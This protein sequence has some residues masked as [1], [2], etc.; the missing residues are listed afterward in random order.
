MGNNYCGK[1][2]VCFECNIH[3]G[4]TSLETK[5]EKRI[6]GVELVFDGYYAKLRVCTENCWTK[7]KPKGRRAKCARYTRVVGILAVTSLGLNLRSGGKRLHWRL[8]RRPSDT[9][10]YYSYAS[11]LLLLILQQKQKSSKVHHFWFSNLWYVFMLYIFFF[12]P[13][14]QCGLV[15]LSFLCFYKYYLYTLI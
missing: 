15:F 11:S 7:W 9:L 13:L 2:A 4:S 6:I 1:G 8:W 14:S 3:K 5:R 12:R 10:K